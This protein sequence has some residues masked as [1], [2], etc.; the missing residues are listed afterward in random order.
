MDEPVAIITPSPTRRGISFGIIAALGG[1]LLYVVFSSPPASLIARVFLLVVGVGMLVLADKL[2]RATALSIVMTDT[3]LMD[4]NGR[5]ICRLDDVTGVE[6]GAFAFKPSNGFLL[7]TKSRMKRSWAPGL[8]W[9]F[10]RKIGVGGATSARQTKFMAE[11]IAVWI[12]RN[13]AP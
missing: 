7:R 4:S 6:R 10:G 9:R 11:A 8:W 12:A 13:G 3:A 1:M 5:E 2:R